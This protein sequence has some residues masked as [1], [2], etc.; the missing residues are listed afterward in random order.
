DLSKVLDRIVRVVE[1]TSPALVAV[2]SFRTVVRAAEAIASGELELQ[3]FVQR[4]ALYLT[5]WQATTFLVG[6][7]SETETRDNPIFTVADGIIWLTQNVERNSVVRKLQVLKERGQAPMPGLH[8]FRITDDGIQVF[9]RIL[10]RPE[11]AV[12][13]PARAR[14]SW[15]VSGLDEMLG[16]GVPAGRGDRARRPLR[17]GQDRVFHPVHRRGRGAGRTRSDRHLRGAPGGLHGPR[18]AP[19]LRPRRDGPPESAPRVLSAPARPVGGRDAR[20]ESPAG[21]SGA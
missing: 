5:S 1:Q 20:G 17:L 12:R 15:G 19:G 11:R 18:Q 8:T 4:L 16:G 14:A 2:D 3:A 7:Y 21:H 9:P 10:P 13:P 6:E